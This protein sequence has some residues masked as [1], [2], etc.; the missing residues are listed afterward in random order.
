MDVDISINHL[1]FL[2][3]ELLEKR[4]LVVVRHQ[5][6]FDFLHSMLSSLGIANVNGAGT[7][8]EALHQAKANAFDIIISNYIIDDERDGQ[9]LLEELRQRHLIPLSTV[10]MII[11]SERSYHNVASVAELTPDDYLIKP[12]STGQLQARIFKAL[13]KKRVFSEVFLR[14]EKNDYP[15]AA[16]A[17]DAVI[18]RGPPHRIEALRI[19]GRILNALKAYG[20]A[21]TLY[22]QVLAEQPLPWAQMGHAKALHGLRQLE[23]ARAVI[24]RLVRNAPRYL[25]AYD[26]LASIEEE[27]GNPFAAQE[28]LQQAVQ[29]SPNNFLR[30]RIVGEIAMRN[31]DFELAEKAYLKVLERCRGSSSQQLTDYAN[32]ARVMLNR[33]AID[34][35]RKVIQELRR[36]LRG[37]KESEYVA[38]VFDSLCNNK[39]GETSKAREAL[40]RALKIRAELGAGIK[41]S[42]AGGT[43]TSRYFDIDLAHACLAVGGSAADR[44][45]PYCIAAGN[46]DPSLRIPVDDGVREL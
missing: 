12:F 39:E 5:S 40:N 29:I 34:R 23:E 11:T 42:G 44:E 26:F 19:K 28:A 10:F 6:T 18:A 25:A 27:M 24:K 17:C 16:S 13:D 45:I 33:N 38:L 41:A 21:E 2:E 8:T 37:N 1:Q 32:L 22:Q 36:Y 15:A 30:Q 31:G 9:Q 46:S 4:V 3:K 14:L 7:S 20:E 35:A 43:V